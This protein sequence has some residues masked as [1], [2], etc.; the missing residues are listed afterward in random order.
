M[1]PALDLSIE[2]DGWRAL[3][4]LQQLAQSVIGAC[5]RESGRAVPDK[6]EVSLLFCDD[7]AIR[8]LNKTWRAKDSATNVLSFPVAA[9]RGETPAPM[10]GDI[11]IAYETT[12]G[13]AA[14]EGKA[15][16]AH[17]AHLIAH[18]FLHLLGYDHES[19]AEAE[20]MEGAERRALRRLGIADPY[21]VHARPLP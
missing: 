16:R 5:A 14:R 21:L 20:E 3:D 13:E 8:Q 18:G 19:E 9:P 10:L 4:G 12:A 6:A 1:D 2:C 11:V 15:L 17:T 7:A